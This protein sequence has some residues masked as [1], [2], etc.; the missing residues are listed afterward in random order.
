MT[1]EVE[2]LIHGVGPCNGQKTAGTK[3]HTTYIC[4]ALKR[5]SSSS[6]LQSKNKGQAFK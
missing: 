3:T 6:F 4:A 5:K 2:T 1:G